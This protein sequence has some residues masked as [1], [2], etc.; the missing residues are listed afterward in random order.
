MKTSSH[1]RLSNIA[2]DGTWREDEQFEAAGKV[3]TRKKGRSA[4]RILESWVK[5]RE[6]GLLQNWEVYGQPA[7]VTDNIIQVWMLQAQAQQFPRSIWVRDA[8]GS[9]WSPEVQLAMRLVQQIGVRI[10]PGITDLLQPTDTDF[11]MSLKASLKA[12]QAEEKKRMKATAAA[13]G[14]RPSFKCSVPSLGRMLD[15]AWA[16]QVEREEQR[17]WT[18]QCLRRNGYLR[19]RPDMLQQKLVLAASQDW[20][21]QLPEGSYRLQS[22][23]LE[24]RG[25]FMEDKETR[26]AALQKLQDS[27]ARAAQCEIAYCHHEGY[28]RV[29]FNGEKLL[30]AHLEIEAD[31]LEDDV[32]L[33]ALPLMQ[34]LDSK[35]QRRLKRAAME[36]PED[37]DKVHTE[38]LKS[39]AKARKKAEAAERRQES[40]AERSAD[41]QQ[42]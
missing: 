35:V 27:K 21:L 26:A 5:L 34:T 13:S 36:N 42:K 19:W 6:A 7:A 8:V 10:R 38:L 41:S 25:L 9:S 39:Q 2:A 15:A 31:E 40:S 14:S 18:P 20:A 24:N 11:A 28:C 33:Q 32:L 23:W 4:G 3:V 30:E 22:K 17:P 29:R 12:A 37:Q 1:C 16:S